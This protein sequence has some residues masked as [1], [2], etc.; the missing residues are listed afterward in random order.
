M[1]VPEEEK[2][3]NT[4]QSTLPRG[5]RRKAPCQGYISKISIHAPA[6]GATMQLGSELQLDTI[7]IHAPARGAT[8]SRRNRKGDNIFQST[9]PRGER[10]AQLSHCITQFYFNPRSREGSDRRAFYMSDLWKNFNPRSREGSDAA[11]EIG[12]SPV[13][14]SIHAPARGATL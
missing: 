9:L 4:F 6:R 8:G 12:F 1:Q 14:I 13:R 3:L 2:Y 11:E 5:E 7:S 10:L